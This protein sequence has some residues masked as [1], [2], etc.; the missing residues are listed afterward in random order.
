MGA[1]AMAGALLG[2][3]AC[4]T[5]VVDG[6]TTAE[7]KFGE[8]QK[9]VDADFAD[10]YAAAKAGLADRKLF[11]TGEEKKVVEAVLLAR[12]SSDT[13]ITVKVKEVAKGRTSIKIRYGLTGELAPAQLLY[14]ALASHL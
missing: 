3:S 7:Y 9:V 10:V 2:L 4:T 14:Q 6:D 8:L 5:V 12:D 1:L 11:V 13:S